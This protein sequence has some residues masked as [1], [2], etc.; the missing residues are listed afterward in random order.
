[1]HLGRAQGILCLAALTAILT[2]AFGQVED[3]PEEDTVRLEQAA[4]RFEAQ[5][6]VLTLFDREGNVTGTV[7]DREVYLVPSLSP[8]GNRIA[9]VINDFF[10]EKNDLWV[11][12]VATGDR[13]Q[14]TSNAGWDTEWVMSPV[15]SPDGT[16]LAYVGMRDGYESIFRRPADGSR[17]EELLY[18]HPGANVWLGDWSPDGRF[19]SVSTSDLVE[20]RLYVLPMEG[21]GEREVTELLQR[22]ARVMAGSFSPDGKSLTYRSEETGINEIYLW[23]LEA[24]E[25]G[26]QISEGGGLFQIRGQWDTDNDEIYYLRVGELV[27][28]ATVDHDSGETTVERTK[29]FE[30]SPAIRPGPIHMS[31]SRNGE[32][33]VVAVPHAPKL[34]QVVVL[35]REGN[36][37]QRLGEPGVWRNPT[38]SPDGSKVAVQAWMKDTS[39]WD[40]Q[41]FDRASG[42]SV[43]V[44]AD[45]HEDNYP[46][47]SPDGSE[48]AY[49]SLRDEYSYIYRKPA[50]GTG[51]ETKI[52]TYEPGAFLAVTDWSSDGRFVSFNDGCWGVLYVVPLGGDAVDRQAMEWLRDEYQVALA[53]FSPDS[54]HIAY[55]TDEVEPDVFNLYIARFDPRQ[56]DGR[57]NDAAP[58]RVSTEDVLGMVS[59]REDGRELYYLS[60]DWE[61][62]AV[63]VSTETGLEIGQPRKLF[64]LPGPLPGGP[65]QWKSASPDGQRFVFVLN[66]P[67]T[68]G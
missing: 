26:L 65:R 67:V 34:E 23:D 17:N 29:L 30:L 33:M 18:R 20:G 8:D 46:I 28:A 51:V 11:I 45:N 4:R 63:D 39:F 13:E 7:G 62:M 60:K 66:V 5:A 61:V 12:D 2:P 50:D 24:G 16:E 6:R 58:L 35:D 43:V 54:R 48:L 56:P 52:F 15:W 21:D 27:V 41:V 42:A 68:I 38:L 31:V 22:D 3:V 14:L 53:R 36:E 59:W 10:A 49:M 57:V 55:L 37:V 32:R 44:T 19:V 25:P 47:W 40:I 9:V 1:M 64:E